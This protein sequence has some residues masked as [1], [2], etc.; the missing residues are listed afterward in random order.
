VPDELDDTAIMCLHLRGDARCS[1]GDLEGGLADL[2]D[3]LRRSE[4]AGRVADIV[5][6]LNYLAEWKWASE[7]PEAGFAEW[8]RALELAERRNIRS[9]GMYSKAA[10]LWVLYEMGDADRVLEWSAD[11]LAI[12]ADR[13]DAAVRAI[14]TIVRTHVLLDQG[15]RSEAIDPEELVAMAER[16]HELAAQAPALIAAATIAHL[17]G[18]DARATAWLEAFETLTDDVAPEYRMADLVRAVQLAVALDRPE[19][20]ERL[21]ASTHPTVDRDRR[22]LETA[23]AILAEALA[24]P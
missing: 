20:A 5:S 23:S 14:A 2:A 9:Q 19:T 21:I 10:A 17:D 11:L 18:D 12:P 22:R 8:E 7:S 13:I 15:R 16:T 3:A 6:S 1:M 24:R 4:A